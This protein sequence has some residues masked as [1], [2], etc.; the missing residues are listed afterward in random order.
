MKRPQFLPSLLMVDSHH[1]LRLR[2][3][4]GFGSLEFM[5]LDIEYDMVL[6][7]PALPE[8]QSSCRRPYCRRRQRQRNRNRA[9]RGT[10]CAEDST[11][12]DDDIESLPRDLA[13]ANIS[14]RVPA[15]TFLAPPVPMWES[16][17]PHDVE[18]GVS[19]TPAF[20]PVGREEPDAPWRGMGG[21]RGE[22]VV[23]NP[24]PFQPRFNTNNDAQ[25]Y[26]GL[27]FPSECLDSEEKDGPNFALDFSGLRDPKSMLQFLYACGE[28]LS[29]R[30]EGYNSVEEG[31]DPTW[32]CFHVDSGLPEEGDY[33]GVP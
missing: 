19:A 13:S 4:I 18:Q 21:D 33:L 5:S 12:N 27:S 7:P 11:E 14:P 23:F 28:M 16:P 3:T 24:I 25:M 30:L 1:P 26:D 8:D 20:P 22:P 31:Y 17:F 10:L 9:P 2:T 29:E 15:P 32:E 6:L